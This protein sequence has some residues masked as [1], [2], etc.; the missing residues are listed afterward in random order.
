[1]NLTTFGRV[2]IASCNVNLKEQ[3]VVV[4]AQQNIPSNSEWKRNALVTR[5]QDQ[6]HSTS[7]RPGLIQ[8]Q[9]LNPM[10]NQNQK[11]D[12]VGILNQNLNLMLNQNQKP[13]QL[14]IPNLYLS[15]QSQSTEPRPGFMQGQ[16]L[17]QNIV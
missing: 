11:P 4:L 17:N 5:K 3:S 8:N 13:D 15:D 14:G 7:P 2:I 6:N 1:M 16:N 10:L 12:Q 9:N